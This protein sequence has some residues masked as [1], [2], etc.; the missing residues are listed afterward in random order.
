MVPIG[1]HSL[2]NGVTVRSAAPEVIESFIGQLSTLFGATAAIER[3]SRTVVRENLVSAGLPP[4]LDVDVSS[5][6]ASVRG[7]ASSDQRFAEMVA[8]LGGA[9]V[10]GG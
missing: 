3:W 2:M 8:A 5:Y 9:A 6:L 10:S 4:E 7:V 1:R